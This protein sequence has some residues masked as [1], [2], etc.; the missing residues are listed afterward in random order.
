MTVSK[1]L[2]LE[3]GDNLIE[4]KAYNGQDIGK[5]VPAQVTIKATLQPTTTAPRLYVLAVGVNAYHDTAF[6][7]T[8]FRG[9]RCQSAGRWAAARRRESYER[10]EVM[11]VF[12]DDATAAN[13]DRTFAELR[14]KVRPQDVFVLFLHKMPGDVD[15]VVLDE[16]DL[17]DEARIARQH[18][19]LLQHV[20]AG[21]VQRMGLAGEDQLHGHLR[22]VDQFDQLLPGLATSRL[23]RL[24]VAKRRANPIVSVSR[25]KA[26]RSWAMT[27]GGSPRRSA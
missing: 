13:L 16:H 6:P 2:P 25:L 18:G 24:Y 12:D 7:E 3:P 23:A 26:R 5:S 11:T 4:V 9:A 17:A 8:P 22:I 21:H 10:V 27:S 14:Q 15:V 19:D 1:T 20:L